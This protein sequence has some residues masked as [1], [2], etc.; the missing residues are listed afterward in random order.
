MKIY[1]CFIFNDELDLLELRLE[2][3]Y[4]EVDY[5]VL[6]E[7]S[8]TLSG[9]N[10]PLNFKLNEDR[11]KKYSQK[12]MYLEAPKMEGMEA[13]S[14]EFFQRNY[15]KQALL[16]C[17]D[18]DIVFVSDVDEIINVKEILKKYSFKKPAVI[19]LPV[20]YYYFNLVSEDIFRYNLVSC[21]TF[22]KEW[23]IGKRDYIERTSELISL[24][25][26][27]TGWHFSY[28]FGE[29]VMKYT[30]KIKSFSH[31]EY[32]TPYYTDSKRLLGCVQSGKDIF[33]RNYKYYFYGQ[34]FLFPIYSLIKKQGLLGFYK[35][36][37]F[38][39]RIK[40]LLRIMKVEVHFL[41]QKIK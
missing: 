11:F 40:T 24:R 34:S 28:L 10:K 31:Q 25:E 14:Y 22:I 27:N 2:Y 13:W 30:E 6:V 1:D 20:C 26:I 38:S 5:F 35:K 4:N 41:K 18:E 29:H 12:I 16:N 33:E 3:L 8:R 37:T 32:N 17:N 23:N 21:Y 19:E 7:S 15:I 39:A 9:L 36:P